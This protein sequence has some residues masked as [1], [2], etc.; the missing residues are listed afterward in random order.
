[1]LIGV[2]GA[3]TPVCTDEHLPDLI[4]NAPA[5]KAAGFAKIVCIAPNDPYALAAWQAQVDPDGVLTLLSDGNLDFSRAC[6]LTVREPGLFL[7]ERTARFLMVT[8][9]AVVTKLN[10]ERSI[11]N[12]A[13]SRSREVLLAA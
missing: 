7:G 2:P 10:V 9:D 8:E 6:G 5:L 4:A 11:L 12:V 1:M 13:V 3:F